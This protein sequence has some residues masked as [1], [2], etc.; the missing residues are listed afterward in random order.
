LF[1]HITALQIFS[2]V[3]VIFLSIYTA[4]KNWK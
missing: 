4:N 3:F 1:G 2:C